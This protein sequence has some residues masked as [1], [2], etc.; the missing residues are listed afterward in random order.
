MPKR[1]ALKPEL[2]TVTWPSVIALRLER[3]QLRV[4]ARPEQLVDV[5]R[6]MVGMHAQVMSA[7]E[8]QLAARLDDI[9]PSD[10][11][12]ALWAE[13]RLVKAW[14][15]RGTLHLLTPEHL[16]AFVAASATRERWHEATWLRFVGLTESRV[17]ALIAAVGDLLSDQPMTRAALADGIAERLGDPKLASA[18][19]SGWG[20]FL[21]APGQR[22]LLCFGPSDGRNVTFVRPSAWLRRPV[23]TSEQRSPADPIDALA[24]LVSRFLSAFPGSSRDMIGRWW[25][26]V[27][28]SLIGQV[29]ERLGDDVTG[30][31]I[32]GVRAWTL[33]EDLPALMAAKPFKGVRLLPGFD[34]FVNELPRRTEGLLPVGYH[35]RIY[36]TA[37][38]VTP[39][40]LVD[41]RVAGTWE[42]TA[43]KTGGLAVQPFERLPKTAV[44]AIDA[45]ADRLAAFLGRFL[46]VSVANPLGDV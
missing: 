28:A 31:E 36:R 9:H 43:G 41:G 39:V 11:R 10:V 12:D 6:D 22:G 29:L 34:P 15:M 38:W 27:R 23:A 4:R 19:R 46:R 8:L 35:E 24:G 20:T 2:P 21:G 3:Q 18:L 32:E 5:V 13:R 16:I 45:E 25:G 14:S 44:R 17:E 30:I 33:R 37:G 1:T 40:V 7:A 42:L 26:A